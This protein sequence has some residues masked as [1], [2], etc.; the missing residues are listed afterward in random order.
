MH[1]GENGRIYDAEKYAT[2]VT[3]EISP[4]MGSTPTRL[5]NH[6]GQIFGANV[7][8]N[9]PRLIHLQLVTAHKGYAWARLKDSKMKTISVQG[10]TCIDYDL[11]AR[12]LQNMD[13][14]A[15]VLA[16]DT[17]NSED[18]ESNVYYLC[19]LV[20]TTSSGNMYRRMGRVFLDEQAMGSH[21]P[22][23]SDR[24]DWVD[25]TLA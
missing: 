20:T 1:A 5:I 4:T 6:Y 13:I 2:Y 9:V 3:H 19:L 8:L 10:T 7:T 12:Q 16:R 15:L 21:T 22:R 23:D 24:S 14:Y 25:V 18:D 11:S 17:M